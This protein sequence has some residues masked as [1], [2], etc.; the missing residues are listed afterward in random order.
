M[1]DFRFNVSAASPV[2]PESSIVTRFNTAQISIAVKSGK[3]PIHT[4]DQFSYFVKFWR[5]YIVYH[6]SEVSVKKPI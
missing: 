5:F 1:F 6:T 3:I 2:S 4:G